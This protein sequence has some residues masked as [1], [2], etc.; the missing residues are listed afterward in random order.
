METELVSPPAF[1]HLQSE[2]S[3]IASASSHNTSAGNGQGQFSCSHALRPT[4]GVKR[5]GG[6]W[7]LHHIQATSRQTCDPATRVSST[8]LLRQGGWPTL[9]SSAAC[10]QWGH[11]S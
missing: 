2:L 6:G 7:P 11:L 1:P 8:V 10:D 4:A 9:L 3:S 5:Q